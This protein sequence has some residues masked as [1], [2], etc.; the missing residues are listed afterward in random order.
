V[1]FSGRSLSLNLL[2]SKK[3]IKCNLMSPRWRKASFVIASVLLATAACWFLPP[4]GPRYQG[5]SLSRWLKDLDFGGRRGAAARLAVR[6]LGTNALPTLVRCLTHHDS[7]WELR[8]FAFAHKYEVG[9]DLLEDDF[10]WHRRAAQGFVEL[11]AVAEPALPVLA[12]AVTNSQAPE[13]VV[14][15]LARLLP[16]SFNVL[17]N[18]A[19]VCNSR[20]SRV[21]AFDGLVQAC[22]Y[23]QCAA[24]SLLVLKQ[25]LQDPNPETHDDAVVALSRIRDGNYPAQVREAATQ[26]LNELPNPTSPPAPPTPPMPRRKLQ[27]LAQPEKRTLNPDLSRSQPEE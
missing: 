14:V 21:K 5:K 17:T 3:S 24:T 4:H 22:S 11:G 23:Q 19:V 20:A 25:A 16:K 8:W 18:A 7:S 15:A 2:N 26:T 9:L 1:P 13:Q 12:Q 27:L 10:Q 6:E